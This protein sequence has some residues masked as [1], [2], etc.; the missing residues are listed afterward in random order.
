LAVTRLA[1]ALQAVEEGR[2][3]QAVAR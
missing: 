2:A 3:V 1:A